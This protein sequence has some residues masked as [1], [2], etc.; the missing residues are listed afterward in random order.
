VFGRPFL[1]AQVASLQLN[2]IT[3][4]ITPTVEDIGRWCRRYVGITDPN[5]AMKNGATDGGMGDPGFVRG[6]GHAAIGYAARH[7]GPLSLLG[8]VERAIDRT[9]DDSGQPADIR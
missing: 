5:G 1:S 7:A 3:S 2:A 8:L 9:K 6:T 4:A